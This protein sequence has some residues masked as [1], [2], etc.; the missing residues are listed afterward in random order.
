MVKV[1]LKLPPLY[2]PSSGSMV[3]VKF[4]ISS[5]LGKLIFMV[6]PSESSCK[7]V[8]AQVVS[9]SSSSFRTSKDKSYLAEP[10]IAQQSLFS[11]LRRLH[12][13]LQLAAVSV[14]IAQ[15][16]ISSFFYNLNRTAAAAPFF[17]CKRTIDQIFNILNPQYQ[18]PVFPPFME[19]PRS[20]YAVRLKK[21]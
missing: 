8:G 13:Q 1:K 15:S 17:F 18:Q 19:N 2:I 20:L 3:R 7:S 4:K 11:S 12:L 14:S 5:G 16:Q 21:K 6:E 9:S 10:V